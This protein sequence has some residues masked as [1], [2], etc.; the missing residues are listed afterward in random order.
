MF[1]ERIIIERHAEALSGVT[2]FFNGRPLQVERAIGDGPDAPVIV[3]EMLNG[4]DR[5]DGDFE[6]AAGQYALWSRDEVERLVRDQY[7]QKKRRTA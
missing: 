4:P 6:Y 5:P 3:V 1:G 2:F 7:G